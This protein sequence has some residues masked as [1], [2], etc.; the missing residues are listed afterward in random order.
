[1]SSLDYSELD[2][3]MADLNVLQQELQL[4][5]ARREKNRTCPLI[6]GPVAP[7]AQRVPW[8]VSIASSKPISVN[9]R[10]EGGSCFRPSRI[11]LP[12]HVE[13]PYQR[14]KQSHTEPQLSTVAKQPVLLNGTVPTAAGA[15]NNNGPH[16]PT[17]VLSTY[18]IESTRQH[19][20]SPRCRVD[21]SL[22]VEQ[23]KEQKSVHW[24]K[25]V[26][27][28]S[29][30]Q[31]LP[32]IRHQTAMG[33]SSVDQ[34]RSKI[35]A[36]IRS[37]VHPHD[38]SQSTRWA[39][40]QYT[41]PGM[42]P[43][44]SKIAV[45][46][47]H[48]MKPSSAPRGTNS[49]SPQPSFPFPIN[50]ADLTRKT[51]DG[52]VKWRKPDPQP[53]SSPVQ[54]ALDEPHLEPPGLKLA[55]LTE[56]RYVPTT[57]RPV[58]DHMVKSGASNS[59]SSNA[60]KVC[61]QQRNDLWS[62]D[63]ELKLLPKEPEQYH[64]YDRKNGAIHPRLV[65]SS[66]SSGKTIL[67]VYQPDR[68]IKAVSIEPHTTAFSILR[69]LLEKNLLRCTTKY[70]LVEK[71][72]SLKLE[73]CF[74]DS[75]LMMDCLIHWNV[76]SENLVFFEER[77]DMYGMFEN[78]AMW[79]GEEISISQRLA[80]SA[81]KKNI[82]L[83]NKELML[84]THVEHLYVRTRDADWKRRYCMLRNSGLYISKRNSKDL[85]S[86]RRLLAF[87]PCLQLYTTT[88]GWTKLKAPT[89]FGFTVRPYTGDES[90]IVHFCAST[91]ASM[92]IWYCLLR[93]ALTGL[94]LLHNYNNRVKESLAGQSDGPFR[95][96]PSIGCGDDRTEF[97]LQAHSSSFQPK[98]R[99]A[100]LNRF[101]SLPYD[102]PDRIC[103]CTDNHSLGW[104]TTG[105]SVEIGCVTGR[106]DVRLCSRSADE[107]VKSEKH[108]NSSMCVSSLSSLFA[109]SPGSARITEV[110]GAKDRVSYEAVHKKSLKR[111]IFR[112]G[113]AERRCHRSVGN[114][115]A[116]FDVGLPSWVRERSGQPVA[117][118][119]MET[120][121]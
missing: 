63:T 120:V 107:V 18:A 45:T 7:K 68:T 62:P 77:E 98:A 71:I 65:H 29:P 58:G 19:R 118:Q 30:E 22:R 70:A 25:D 55:S 79:L 15:R 40:G 96:V 59:Y 38:L 37:L 60:N 83:T 2:K 33:K 24:S 1:M 119:P 104:S 91:E 32:S 97:N 50:L 100:S 26:V 112:T 9:K 17:S 72:P 73:R 80:D 69:V 56:Y 113:P 5:Q 8:S 66:G 39:T 76:R 92:R 12:N 111:R 31:F 54:H 16:S 87:K 61:F 85:S 42:A 3:W 11:E 74:E 64:I 67:R 13:Q 41:L 102:V 10:A 28:L 75:E 106:L 6:N 81:K 88:G 93:I 90:N 89:P 53:T 121:M 51:L 48:S 36:N 21:P 94:E 86:Y 103:S 109:C 78:P 115:S 114:I 4:I 84:P 110:S 14:L 52:K 99:S 46:R 82:Y 49:E 34:M 108:R 95:C 35:E 47:S 116:P 57:S 117:T 43:T 101:Q 105:S 27:A 20:T 23:T 44:E